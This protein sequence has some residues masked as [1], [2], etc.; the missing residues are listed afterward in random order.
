MQLYHAISQFV[1]STLNK[2]MILILSRLAQQF[3]FGQATLYIGAHCMYRLLC[4]LVPTVCTGY[5]VYWCPL[6]G[7]CYLFC[8]CVMGSGNFFYVTYYSM[9]DTLKF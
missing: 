7:V 8:V 2:K 1:P 6:Y 3:Y 4:I 5:S 9:G